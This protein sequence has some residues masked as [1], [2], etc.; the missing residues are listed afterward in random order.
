MRLVCNGHFTF[1]ISFNPRICKRCDREIGNWAV[2]LKCFNPRI[3]KRCD[4]A[5]TLQYYQQK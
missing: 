3:C 1:L 4:E 5:D 2:Q